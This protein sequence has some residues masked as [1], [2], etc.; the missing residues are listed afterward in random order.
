M[1][2]HLN[3]PHASPPSSSK[4]IREPNAA[5]PCQSAKSDVST[6]SAPA[7]MTP[8]PSGFYP[9]DFDV[10]CARGK[11]AK[12]HPGNQWFRSLVKENLED[13]SAAESKLEKSFV[14]SKI[15]KTVRKRGTP[16]GGF[17]KKLQAGWFEVGDRLSR[18]KIGQAFRDALHTQYKSSTKAKAKRRSMNDNSDSEDESHMSPRKPK[19]L[20]TE[21]TSSPGSLSSK[22]SA[23]DDY[24]STSVSVAAVL[25]NQPLPTTNQTNSAAKAKSTSPSLATSTSTFQM[26]QQDLFPSLPML[27][28]CASTFSAIGGPTTTSTAAA[29][30]RNNN[31]NALLPSSNHF[32]RQQHQQQ[33]MNMLA[34]EEPPA[35]QFQRGT[36]QEFEAD[37]REM[38]QG[39][40]FNSMDSFGSSSTDSAIAA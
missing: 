29:Q 17:V 20:K 24:I 35:F 40:L 32:G 6:K 13:Y 14:V 11:A 23:S 28:E 39:Q 37:V 21:K 10:I 8:M 31:S 38:F 27:Q 12:Q 34:E 22:A 2:G 5:S 1:Q 33:S 16:N 18:E 26:Q 4:V 3:N 15:I 25:S 7:G 36:T 19:A 9:G 30:F